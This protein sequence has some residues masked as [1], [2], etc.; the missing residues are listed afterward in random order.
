M[1]YLNSK[2]GAMTTTAGIIIATIAGASTIIGS[3]ITSSITS[4]SRVAV[5]EERESNHYAELVK[6][7]EASNEKLDA[8]T[9]AVINQKTNGK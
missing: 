8:L 4:S 9:A 5:I 6:L 1:K 3:F 7:I 2:R